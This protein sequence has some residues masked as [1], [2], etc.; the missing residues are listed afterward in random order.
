MADI[1]HRIQINTPAKKIYQ[2]I[3]SAAGLSNWWT[4]EVRTTS[5]INSIAEF[6]FDSIVT[7]MQIV[8]LEADRRVE[9]TCVAGPEEWIGTRLYFD[10]VPERNFTILRFGQTGWQ[11]ASDFYCHCNCK[12]SYFLHSLKSFVENGKGTPFP[13]DTKI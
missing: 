13:D 8:K 10:L 7:K 4:K 6:G 2:D 12:W 11:N 3:V 9:W 1:L 5:V